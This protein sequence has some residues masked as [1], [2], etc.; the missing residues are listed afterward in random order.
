MS[1]NIDP[2]HD[3]K[4]TNVPLLQKALDYIETHPEEWEQSCWIED[5][6]LACGTVACL[7]GHIALIDGWEVHTD[8]Y[9][10]IRGMVR[11][12]E[13]VSSVSEAAAASLGATSDYGQ[14][15]A[16]GESLWGA[17]NTRKDLWRI[18][19][20]LVDGALTLPLDLQD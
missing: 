20:N 12:D 15:Y 6:P 11:G 2:R 17:S 1:M 5:S 13:W 19:N 3:M 8:A 4:V 16:R 7:A 14:V 18:A 9:G 10:I